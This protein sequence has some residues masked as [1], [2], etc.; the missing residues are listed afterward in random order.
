[1]YAARVSDSRDILGGSG[2][3]SDK[4]FGGVWQEA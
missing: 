3:N 1:M 4:C 2:C